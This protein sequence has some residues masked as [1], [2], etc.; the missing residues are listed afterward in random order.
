MGVYITQNKDTY[1]HGQM[2]LAGNIAYG[3][4]INGVVFHRTNRG[5]VKLNTMF[6]NGVVP[7]LEYPEE[8]VQDWHANL[9]KSRQPYSGI[10]INNAKGVKLWSNNVAARYNDDYVFKI[11]LDGTPAP[12]T[13]G[14]NKVCQGTADL[15]LDNVVAEA[16]DPMVCGLPAVT[17]LG[18]TS[19]PM[20]LAPTPSP[21]TP[22]P[23]PGLT[24]PAYYKIICGGA[25][26]LIQWPY[27]MGKS[28]SPTAAIKSCMADCDNGDC[29]AFSLQ[30]NYCPGKE[31]LKLCFLCKESAEPLPQA[32]ADDPFNRM[33]K[34]CGYGTAGGQF[35]ITP[36]A[37]AM[38]NVNNPA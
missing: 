33:G 29:K 20:T 8:T 21:T 22:A 28:Y 5:A 27:I 12:L 32:C 34:F 31:D 7:R 11:K 2:E 17:T 36:A 14:N 38:Y 13:G 24:V 9:S 10:V 3:N 6:D 15:N 25:C 19:S 16:T 30:D 1:L 23:T 26:H 37:K 18:P 35:F 4:S